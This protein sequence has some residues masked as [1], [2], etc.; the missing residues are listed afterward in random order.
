MKKTLTLQSLLLATVLG[1]SGCAAT[2]YGDDKLRLGMAT[3]G[4]DIMWVPSK[5]DIVHKMLD[6]VQVQPSDIVYDLGSG[7][8]IITIEAAKKYGARAVGIEYNGNLVALA[9]RNAQRAGL[10][11]ER[12]SFRQGDV[13][14]EDFSEAT[15]VTL[16]MGESINARLMPKLLKMRPGTRVVSNTFRIESWI[17]DRE[18][19]SASGDVAFVWTVPAPIEGRWD[20]SGIP[21][22]RAVTMQISQKKQ[23]FNADIDFDGKRVARIDDG[24]IA[25][26]QMS[27]EFTHANKKYSLRGQ[28]EGSRFS[29]RLNDDPRLPVS[30]MLRP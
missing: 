17:P 20:F 8:G 13:F 10:P 11:Q 5:I 7:D 12:V 14:V 16:Y 1:L 22:A 21:D 29:G 28:V 26:T 3:V 23:F 9:Q 4:K 19:R 2:N 15:V 25:G 27:L 18:L 30:G 24:L 6:A